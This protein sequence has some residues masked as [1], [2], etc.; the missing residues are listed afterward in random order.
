MSI[1]DKTTKINN[2]EFDLNFVK[3]W[4]FQKLFEARKEMKIKLEEDYDEKKTIDSYCYLDAII[5]AVYFEFP[6]WK[7]G[8]IVENYLIANMHLTREKNQLGD[9]IYHDGKTLEIKSCV[10]SP[11]INKDSQNDFRFTDIRT[12][13][14]H[15]L[16]VGTD[17]TN[18][19]NPESRFFLL[20]KEQ[21]CET[22]DSVKENG[23][24]MI[25][26]PLL[27]KQSSPARKRKWEKIKEFEENFSDLNKNMDLP[28]T[29][30]RKDMLE[31]IL[32]R[33]I[34][35]SS[36]L[37]VDLEKLDN[38]KGITLIMDCLYLTGSIISSIY[39]KWLINYFKPLIQDFPK[40]GVLVSGD[41]TIT[42]RTSSLSEN[43]H[44]WGFRDYNNRKD[45]SIIRKRTDFY[46]FLCFNLEEA[47][48]FETIEH[49]FFYFLKISF[50]N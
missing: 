2:L 4:D 44:Y 8:K 22:F 41:R 30:K 21:L 5:E 43:K 12:D 39:K 35:N 3:K 19:P 46:L 48:S 17:L 18:T 38:L 28:K 31:T 37:K 32:N 15:Y 25:R 36:K 26:I 50:V 49:F 45:R 13:S 20:T 14:D 24:F 11:Q 34:V 27:K 9:C 6:N 33:Q 16:L 40:K 47:D 23:C 7:I 1:L 10:I 29:F 42:F